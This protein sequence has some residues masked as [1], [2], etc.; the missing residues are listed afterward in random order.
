MTSLGGRGCWAV[1]RTNRFDLAPCAGAD[2]NLVSAP[3]RGADT[4]CSAT[5][6]WT[7]LTGGA[8]GRISLLSWLAFRMRVDALVPLTRPTFVVVNE[9][10]VHRHSSVGVAASIGLET[11]FL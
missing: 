8:L 3:G 7:T 11:L 5:A 4:N 10:S 9:G 1:L 6:A 2:V